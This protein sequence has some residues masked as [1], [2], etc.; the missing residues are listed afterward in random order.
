MGDVGVEF[1]EAEGELG[2][3]L[4]DVGDGDRGRGRWKGVHCETLTM[5]FGMANGSG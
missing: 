4:F 1:G 3:E 5:R 2:S